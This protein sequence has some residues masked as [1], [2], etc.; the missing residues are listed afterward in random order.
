MTGCNNFGA[1]VNAVC[2]MSWMHGK[3]VS[4]GPRVTVS[5]AVTMCVKNVLGDQRKLQA[6]HCRSDRADMALL[7][8]RVTQ[9]VSI[10]KPMQHNEA[11][12][13]LI[14]Y[15]RNTRARCSWERNENLRAQRKHRGAWAGGHVIAFSSINKDGIMTCALHA[16]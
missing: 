5:S 6:T 12:E 4:C 10:V 14:M 15:G 2:A 9:L 11:L 13:Q 16:R 3:C 1:V 7:N 8:Q